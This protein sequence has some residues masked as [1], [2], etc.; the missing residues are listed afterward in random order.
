MSPMMLGLNLALTGGNGGGGAA[1][2]APQFVYQT[3]TTT[4][5]AALPSVPRENRKKSMDRMIWRG[6][7]SG[8]SWFPKL[9]GIW[10]GDTEGLE[11]DWK[12]NWKTPGTYDLVKVGTPTF[13]AAGYFTTSANTSYYETN[14]PLSAVGTRHSFGFFNETSG[15][16]GDV[17]MGAQDAGGVGISVAAKLASGFMNC[18]AMGTSVS[19]TLSAPFGGMG[20][21]DVT[22]DSDTTIRVMRDGVKREVLT[23]AIAT[24]ASNPTIRIGGAAGNASFSQRRIRC[25]Y[26][27]N[28]ALTEAEV[29]DLHTSVRDYLDKTRQG[30]INYFNPDS[31]GGML[32]VPILVHAGTIPAI[33]AAYEAKRQGQNVALLGDWLARSDW[34]I[35]GHPGAGLG[36]IDANSY[37]AVSG[38]FREMLKWINTVYYGRSDTTSQAGLSVEAKAWVACVRHML[39]P[40]NATGVLPGLDIPVYFSKGLT[41]VASQGLGGEITT[42]EG[43]TY[44]CRVGVEA[45]YEGQVVKLAGLPYRTGT[46][47]AGTGGEAFNGYRGAP[48]MSLPF[49]SVGGATIVDPYVTPGNPASGL[50]PDLITPPSLSPGDPDPGIQGINLRLA[51]TTNSGKSAGFDQSPPPNFNPLRFE[52]L[53]RLYAANPTEPFGAAVIKADLVNGTEYDV[54]NGTSRLSTDVA[55][56]GLAYAAATTD[57]QRLAVIKDVRD[58]NRGFF[59]WHQSSGDARIPAALKT[60]LNAYGPDATAFLDPGDDGVPFWPNRAYIRDPVYQLKNTGFIHTGTDFYNV[61]NG[62]ALRNTRTVTIA[63]YPA[64]KH[65]GRHIAVDLGSGMS[66]YSEGGM[67]QTGFGGTNGRSPIS[68]DAIVPDKAL[69]T[70]LIVPVA[71]SITKVVQYFYRMEFTISL[72]GQSAGM[73]AAI[74]IE[75][76]VAVQDVD[77]TKFR[78]RMAA[79]PD[80]VPPV[81]PQ[82]N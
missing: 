21:I 17:A 46:E 37:T 30:H 55:Q 54:N 11:P 36:F 58:Y 72:A 49:S 26:V 66:I 59:Y 63:S 23:S 1:P 19:S 47:A 16:V 6:Q 64:D 71:A 82:V 50:L 56:S 5:A 73:L 28:Q 62:S 10:I 52:G 24:P 60:G 42:V 76:N 44:R 57:A 45:G 2:P 18:R 78:T 34:D 29:L 4:L 8:R 68:R 39:D 48:T 35:A 32:T 22:R 33:C 12:V 14:I 53:G 9:L 65:S 75:D 31:D 41:S 77:D 61:V 15:S 69:N 81:L 74:A 7:Q 43:R 25:A 51:F 20:F 13:N 67:N 38:I 70:W 79:T 3:Q 80:S 40:A 27:A